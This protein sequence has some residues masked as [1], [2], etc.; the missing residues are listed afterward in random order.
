MHTLR[1]DCR[2]E[3]TEQIV[4]E[5]A[6]DSAASDVLIEE[7][8][9]SWN[10]GGSPFEDRARCLGFSEIRLPID[11]PILDGF[12]DVSGPDGLG[13]HQVGDRASDA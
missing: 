2:G 1:Q 5:K 6:G 9:C 13:V 11:A 10:E 3:P 7:D 12:G 8:V 4:R